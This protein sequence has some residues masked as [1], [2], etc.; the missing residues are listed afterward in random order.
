MMNDWEQQRISEILIENENGDVGDFDSDVPA[1]VTNNSE[2][3]QNSEIFSPYSYKLIRD[4]SSSFIRV[5][6]HDISIVPVD[7][8]I[9]TK[10]VTTHPTVG[11]LSYGSWYGAAFYTVW[12]DSSGD[13]IQLFGRVHYILMGNVD[14]FNSQ[15][16]DFNLYQNYPNP[17]NPS[18]SIEY[19]VGS[20]EYVTLKVYDLLGR[21][22]AILVDEYAP[23]GRYEVD[24]DGSKFS[25][26]VYFYRLQAGEFRETR[27]MVLLR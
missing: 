16:K 19:R 5:N 17:F 4:D 2:R 1:L 15:Q 10:V 27:K 20:D 12:E 8:L 24:F 18:T 13:K 26:G 3:G 11:L 9:Q 7:T 23:A 14:Y 6:Y 22:V 21:E 25:S